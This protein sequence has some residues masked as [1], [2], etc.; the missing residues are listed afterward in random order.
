MQIVKLIPLPQ[1][2]N[3]PSTLTAVADVLNEQGDEGFEVATVET[4]NK[5]NSMAQ[6]G[7]NLRVGKRFEYNV[8]QFSF[9]TPLRAQEAM[10]RAGKDGWELVCIYSQGSNN[11]ATVAV[12]KRE[13][14]VEPAD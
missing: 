13:L 8:V 4:T 10:D 14:C 3:S 1:V 11:M 5:F 12:L 2:G 7:M 9:K 6:A